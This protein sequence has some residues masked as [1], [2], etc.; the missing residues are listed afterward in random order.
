MTHSETEWSSSNQSM[1]QVHWRIHCNTKFIVENSKFKR[2]AKCQNP[3]F[4]YIIHIHVTASHC[5]VYERYILIIVQSI[6]GHTYRESERRHWQKLTQWYLLS[7]RKGI[8]LVKTKWFE[9]I[10]LFLIDM[11]FINW[12]SIKN[13]IKW[14]VPSYLLPCGQD[15]SLCNLFV[16]SIY[17]VK[18]YL[19]VKDGSKE[20]T[21][22]RI[23]SALCRVFVF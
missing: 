8:K 4:F 17:L 23:R 11:Y 5:A 2:R 1:A 20:Y 10:A 3:I 15:Y 12:T 13:S 6:D 21:S 16:Q 7:E 9:D 18:G 14:N 22:L 19:R